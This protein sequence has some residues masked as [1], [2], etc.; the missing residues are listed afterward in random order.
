MGYIKELIRNKIST[1][2]VFLVSDLSQQVKGYSG[3][4]LKSAL[5]YAVKNKDLIRISRGVYVFSHNYSRLELANKFR[6]P[7]YIS[8]YTIL[9]EEGV[10]F[11]PYS[12]IYAVS[13]RSQEIEIDGQKYIYRKIKDD[14]LLNQAGT[15]GINGVHKAT[16]E[17]AICDKLYLDGDEFFDNLRNVNWEL[18]KKLNTDVYANNRVIGEFIKKNSFPQGCSI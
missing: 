7:S 6:R 17:R 15:I 4:K 10:V 3:A 11:Q 8:L 5:K 16:Q 13:Q 14:I 1:Q 2:T 12:A 9:Q 18:M